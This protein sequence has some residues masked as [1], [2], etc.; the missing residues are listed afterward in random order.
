MI[1]KLIQA[2]KKIKDLAKKAG[3]LRGKARQTQIMDKNLKK[4]LFEQAKQEI[5]SSVDQAI[6][7][8]IA[9]HN[10]NYAAFNWDS[11]KEYLNPS[12]DRLTEFFAS[13][14]L[15]ANCL[16]DFLKNIAIDMVSETVK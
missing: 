16:D 10:S 8:C 11:L 4:Q 7:A 2:M 1:M 13:N 6:D 9:D 14:G 15:D 3:D 5:Y 12:R